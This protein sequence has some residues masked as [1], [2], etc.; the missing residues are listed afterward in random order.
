MINIRI[1]RRSKLERLRLRY[2]ILYI[3]TEE[4]SNA[5]IR[6]MRKIKYTVI[7]T[8]Q[9]LNRLTCIGWIAL[10]GSIVHSR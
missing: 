3:V 7:R 6:T 8:C 4:P 2:T 5:S 9:R 1:Y 10:E